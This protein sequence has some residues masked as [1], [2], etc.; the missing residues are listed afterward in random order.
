MPRAGGSKSRR[1]VSDLTYTWITRLSDLVLESLGKWDQPDQECIIQTKD[2]DKFLAAQVQRW[3]VEQEWAISFKAEVR[4]ELS[5]ARSTGAQP[6][7]A[8][9]LTGPKV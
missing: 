9:P 8:T 5:S 7:W 2:V 3:R 6:A 4:R 1:S